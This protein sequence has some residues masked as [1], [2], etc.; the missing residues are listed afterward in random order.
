MSGYNVP[1]SRNG[2]PLPVARGVKPVGPAHFQ[3]MKGPTTSPPTFGIPSWSKNFLPPAATLAVNVGPVS[4]V[5]GQ[6]GGVSE[7]RPVAVSRRPGQAP[8]GNQPGNTGQGGSGASGA[9]GGSAAS[10][11]SGPFHITGRLSM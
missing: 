3:G 6:A 11:V 9:G 1:A 10:P 8:G 4:A 5:R 7:I 2:L